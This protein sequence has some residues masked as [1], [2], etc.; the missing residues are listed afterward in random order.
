MYYLPNPI[1]YYNCLLGQL[2]PPHAEENL[3]RY[4]T[5]KN[6]YGLRINPR[7]QPL[8]AMDDTWLSR[9]LLEMESLSA[10]Y[11]EA[12]DSDEFGTV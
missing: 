3:K 10:I 7:T 11:C 4:A 6:H 5:N 2:Y 12:S 8:A 9:Q 1:P